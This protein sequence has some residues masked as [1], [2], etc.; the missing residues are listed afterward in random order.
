MTNGEG[1]NSE[2]LSRSIKLSACQRCHSRKV[3]CSGETPACS[4]CRK[5]GF[6]D[7]CSYPTHGRRV[8]VKESYLR[9]LIAENARLRARQ[10]GPQIPDPNQ[11]TDPARL[12]ED[13]DAAPED[14]NEAFQRPVVSPGVPME[15]QPW[16]VDMDLPQ[17]PTPISEGTDTAF[18]TR[19]RQAI[20]DPD[21]PPRFV[22]PHVDY[23][24][25]EEIMSLAEQ[26]IPWPKPARA[27]MLVDVA[28][29]HAS[30]GYHIVRRSS[31]LE[32]LEKSLTNPDWRDPVMECKLRALFGLGE[33]CASKFVPPNQPFPGLSHFAQATKI[34]NYLGEWP[35]LDLIEIRLILSIF[36][37]T[38]NRIHSAYALAGSA[39]RMAVILGLHVNIHESQL[40]DSVL[41]EHRNRLFWTAFILDRLWAC[42]LGCPPALQDQD[43]QVDLPTDPPTPS[44]GSLPEDFV[45]ARYVT[46][47]VKLTL[48]MNKVVR[49]IYGK[50]KIT[51]LFN[52]VQKRVLELKDWVEELPQSFR[53]STSLSSTNSAY[54]RY[55]VLSLH[56]TLNQTIILATRPILLYGLRLSMFSPPKP[57]PLAAKSL[58]DTCVT[59]AR[60]TCRLLS[61]C[62][63]SGAFPPL[64]H[65][66]TQYLFS[67][68]TVLAVS[69][70]LNHEDTLSDK[71]WFEESVQLLEQL[72][73]SGN[74]PASEFHRHVKLIIAALAKVEERRQGPHMRNTALT[75]SSVQGE[76]VTTT[77][78][79]DTAPVR[80]SEAVITSGI[81][82]TAE[83][84]EAAL[85][86]PS[87]QEFLLQPAVEMQ[88][89]DVTFDLFTDG[90]GL[91]WPE[92]DFQ[93][94]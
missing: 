23:A 53:I 79:T 31:V 9:Q 72:K 39:I 52:K 3:R 76:S 47:Y 61:S 41:R 24:G 55:D 33:M 86:E 71:E 67:A 94:Q 65:D 84:A 38:L 87:L 54:H 11:P 28:F 27:R 6:A 85:A 40:P 46:A 75:R 21:G 83:T 90:N 68:L 36:S 44:P 22:P 13:D 2:P 4:N 30:R 29:M 60:H 73:D 80:H 88:F 82:A 49:S 35:T 66:L 26:H 78:V 81:N 92:F 51:T 18:A 42:K 19:F 20:S 62:W 45:Q 89:P 48:I 1:S 56:M 15:G 7:Q 16:F 37:F 74:L 25:D 8:K 50:D 64:Y 70:L 43:I 17:N 91:Y 58:M 34:L 12:P 32:A 5:G 14:Q 93:G 77:S 10:P 69:S 63:I 57:I 59:C